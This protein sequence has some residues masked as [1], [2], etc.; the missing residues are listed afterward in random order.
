MVYYPGIAIQKPK[1]FQLWGRPW[2]V[3]RTR[4]TT[5]FRRWDGKIFW[6]TWRFSMPWKLFD[7]E[8]INRK[9]F[10]FYVLTWCYSQDRK[11]QEFW[12]PLP[13]ATHRKDGIW[14]LGLY[15]YIFFFCFSF[16]SGWRWI[17]GTFSSTSGLLPPPIGE[18]WIQHD[19]TCWKDVLTCSH[20]LAV[21]GQNCWIQRD[22][23]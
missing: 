11:T 13:L 14:K 4:R 10:D 7:V 23:C 3:C 19:S 1:Q 16:G 8:S 9:W 21:A 17:L 20:I 12:V 2:S 22:L 15:I 6:K 5:D 18:W